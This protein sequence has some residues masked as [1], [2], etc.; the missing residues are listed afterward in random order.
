MENTK[1]LKSKRKGRRKMI[2]W[3]IGIVVF[4][5][6]LFL[7][8]AMF[9]APWSPLNKEHQEAK[10]LP[11]KEIDFSK[12]KD[13]TYVGE[14]AGGMYKWRANQVQVTVASGKVSDIEPYGTLD[15]NKKFTE[16]DEMYSRVLKAQTLQVDVVTGA[17]L[18]SKAYLK[19]VEDALVKAE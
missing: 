16:R 15:P 7:V 13:G 11:I 2:G 5:G 6:L 19:G 14:Y 8:G 10:S 9:C 1:K 18:T 17:T 3:L 12:L 4:A